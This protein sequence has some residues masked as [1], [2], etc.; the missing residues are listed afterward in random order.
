MYLAGTRVAHPRI[1]LRLCNM[2]PYSAAHGKSAFPLDM[3][4]GCDRDCC[5]ALVRYYTVEIALEA[6]NQTNPENE[7]GCFGA[8]RRKGEVVSAPAQRSRGVNKQALDSAM[9]GTN[10]A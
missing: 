7:T 1:D 8:A 2:I 10:D 6:R 9:S 3:C 4:R 5:F